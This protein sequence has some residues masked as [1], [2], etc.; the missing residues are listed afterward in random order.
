MLDTIVLPPQYLR[1]DSA[2]EEQDIKSLM[3]LSCFGYNITFTILTHIK[4]LFEAL[5]KTS[6]E[7]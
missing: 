3:S 1:I 7:E 5:K 2:M 6:H 4:K